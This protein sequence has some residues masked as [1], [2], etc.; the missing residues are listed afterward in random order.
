MEYL[1]SAII[2]YLLGSIPAAYL[3]MKKSAG[4]DISSAGSGNVGAMNSYEVSNSKIIGMLV[5]LLDALKGLLSVY[6][7]LLIFGQIFIF[8]ALSLLFAVLSHCYNPWL[9]FKGGRGLAAAAGGTILLFPILPV[10]WILL[11][12]IIYFV[13]KDII[14]S[15]IWAIIMTL[16][17]IFTSAN[18]A[19]KYTFPRAESMSAMI[20]F[21]AG[22]LIIIFNRHLK[23]LKELLHNKDFFKLGKKDE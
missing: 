12:L 7:P 10:L 19:F 2:G 9:D 1:I 15:N 13:K 5:L 4:I 20:L 6:I 8:P 22:I 17:I 18:I 21:S 16:L 3:V 14:F 11:W 23:P